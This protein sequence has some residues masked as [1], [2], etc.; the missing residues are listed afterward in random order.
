MQVGEIMT[1]DVVTVSMDHTLREVSEIFE[2]EGFH[3]VVVVENDH[4]L[5][6]VSDRDVLKT[7]SPFIGKLAE[8]ATDLNSLERPVHQW[9]TRDVMSV[10]PDESAA[11]AARMMLRRGVS[12]LPVIQDDKLVGIVTLRDVAFTAI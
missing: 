6:V 8:R 10:D 2:L 1:T 11:W 3:H 12:C 7:V 5:G 9:M 4:V